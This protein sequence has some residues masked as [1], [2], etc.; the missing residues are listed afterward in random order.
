MTMGLY[1]LY[2]NLHCN[3][4]VYK[5]SELRIVKFAKL[6]EQWKAPVLNL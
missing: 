4:V 5:E 3:A 1:D 6:H 2:L